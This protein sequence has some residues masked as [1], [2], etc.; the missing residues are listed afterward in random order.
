MSFREC[1]IHRVAMLVNNIAGFGNVWLCPV[2]GCSQMKPC[3]S[4]KPCRKR[5]PKAPEA[6][7]D[8]GKS[9]GKSFSGQGSIIDSSLKPMDTESEEKNAA[10]KSTQAQLW[11]DYA[12]EVHARHRDDG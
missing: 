8:S 6:T 9:I 3:K 12:G 5:K 4:G 11:N 1:S 2:D 7:R 10:P